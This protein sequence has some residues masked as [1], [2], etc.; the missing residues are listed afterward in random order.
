MITAGK[1]TAA[2]AHM[3]PIFVQPPAGGASAPH[4]QPMSPSAD[5]MC[6]GYV[7]APA[8][9][10]R[11]TQLPFQSATFHPTAAA[12]AQPPTNA[13]G[14]VTHESLAAVA[15][16]PMA[17]HQTQAAAAGS[18]MPTTMSLE[19]ANLNGYLPWNAITA[20][21]LSAATS[22]QSTTPAA[23]GAATTPATDAD[24]GKF[25][26]KPAPANAGSVLPSPAESTAA[27]A[28][29]AT[30]ISGECFCGAFVCGK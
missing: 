6:S 28:A 29:V 22:A 24:A 27:A 18:T 14:Y 2:A 8:Y 23:T 19:Q 20:S 15:V 7:A 4:Q 5:S 25:D 3:A 26:Q 13:N 17:A 21:A 30:G 9:P 16:A 10:S 12:V 11:P 1:F